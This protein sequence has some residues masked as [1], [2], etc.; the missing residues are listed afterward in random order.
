MA[1]VDI[2]HSSAAVAVVKYTLLDAQVQARVL[3]AAAEVGAG[4]GALDTLLL[5][6][7]EEQ[8]DAKFGVGTCKGPKAQCRLLKACERVKKMLS[9][10]DCTKVSV[11]G[12]I[13]DQDVWIELTRG[14]LELMAVPVCRRVSE[15]VTR[16]LGT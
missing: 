15:L 11:D 12:L 16:V 5:Q 3:A 1:L 8:I 10:V 6:H 9:T 7:F 4:G 14:Q 13:P 2:G